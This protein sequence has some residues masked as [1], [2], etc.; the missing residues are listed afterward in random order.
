MTNKKMTREEMIKYLVNDATVLSSKRTFTITFPENNNKLFG[1]RFIIKKSTCEND[2]DIYL[3]NDNNALYK[4]AYRIGMTE[5][6]DIKESSI[7]LPSTT[8]KSNGIM[9]E[10]PC[11]FDQKALMLVLFIVMDPVE[12]F[13]YHMSHLDDHPHDHQA[14]NNTGESAESIFNHNSRPG[15]GR[16]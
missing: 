6:T 10:Y 7:N 16:I 8:P 1:K 15:G 11:Y 2:V 14:I 3:Y 9:V 5:I 4:Q 12:H 13:F